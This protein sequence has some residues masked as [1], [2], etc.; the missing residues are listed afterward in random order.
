MSLFL[1]TER[2]SNIGKNL[3][4]PKF[5]A[6][7]LGRIFSSIILQILDEFEGQIFLSF[8][9]VDN[10]KTSGIRAVIKGNM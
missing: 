5:M 8:F 7:I 9:N 4:C 2:V 10:L 1:E 6:Y 3:S